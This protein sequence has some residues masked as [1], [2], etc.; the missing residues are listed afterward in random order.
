MVG[1]VAAQATGNSGG[2][3]SR[4]SEIFKNGLVPC[5]H[6]DSPPDA[7]AENVRPDDTCTLE[8]IFKA[9]ARF[10]NFM[11]GFAGAFV[12]FKFVNGS[13]GLVTAAGNEKGLT[14]AKD[15]LMNAFWG[16]LL[17]LITYVLVNQII[18]GLLQLKGPTDV[19]QNPTN[20][21]KT[22]IPAEEKK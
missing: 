7:T 5:G 13:F 14:E 4:F 8:D 6:K 18:Y 17:I 21:I 12:V 20:F 16:F 22:Q 1:T 2:S 19:L 3:S 9:F 10:T 11:I 15:K